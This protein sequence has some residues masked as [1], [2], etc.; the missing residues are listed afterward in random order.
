[1]STH[2]KALSDSEIEQLGHE[3]NELKRQVKSDIGERDV[4]YIKNIQRAVRYSGVLGRAFLFLSFLWPFWVLGVAL[5]ALSKILDNMELGHNVIHGQFD[6][7]GDPHLNGKAFEWD[8][9]GTSDNWRETHNY[10]HH[11]YTN[12]EGHDEDIGYGFIRVF[13]EQKWNPWYLLQPIYTFFFAFVFQWGVALQNVNLKKEKGQPYFRLLIKNNQQIIKKIRW[14]LVKDYLV[15]PLLAGPMFVSVFLGNMAANAIRSLWTFV[16]IFCGHFTEKTVMFPGEAKEKDDSG[17][18]YLRQIQGSSNIQGSRL[19]HIM[20]GNLS[21]QI[22]HHLFPEIPANRYHELAP[23]VKT[24]CERYGQTY[25]TG[26]LS[27]QFSQ[28]VYRILRH[29]F[30]STASA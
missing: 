23:K 7:M 25:N 16:I 18:W 6:F 3:I 28:V 4:R 10:R 1:V 14:Q 21:H 15:F 9:L 20:S 24:I 26:R 19:F 29:A 22:E 27:V 12:I 2:Y 11:T 17:H 5:L 13:A 30:P 8:I